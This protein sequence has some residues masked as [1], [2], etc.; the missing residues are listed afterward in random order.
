MAETQ[1]MILDIKVNYNEAKSTE[2][3]LKK[4]LKDG[5]IIRQRY[6]EEMVTLEGVIQSILINWGDI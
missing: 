5:E 2:E 1:Q 3:K 4:L 6:D